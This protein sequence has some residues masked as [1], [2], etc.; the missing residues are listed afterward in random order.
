MF[1]G[2]R[3]N[4]DNVGGRLFECLQ[5]SVEGRVGEHVDLVDDEYAVAPLGRSHHNLVDK[6]AHGVDA[7]VTRCIHL[8]DIQ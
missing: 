3:Q 8:D 1:L 5:E 6:L 4:E 7:V 2:G